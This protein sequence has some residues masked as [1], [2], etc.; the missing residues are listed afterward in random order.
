MPEA[1]ALGEVLLGLGRAL[2]VEYDVGAVLDSLADNVS[3]LLSLRGAAVSVSANRAVRHVASNCAALSG[4][5]A[6]EE[7]AQRGPTFDAVE[8]GLPVVVTSLDNGA[9]PWPEYIAQ[10]AAAGLGAVAAVP[11]SGHT[12]PVALTLAHEHEHDWSADELQV[13][14]MFARIAGH[15]V[16]GG[17]QLVKHRV[18]AEQLQ[19]A[20]DSRVIIEQ[21]KGFIAD[22]RGV[23][24]DDAFVIMRKYANDHHA[25]LRSVADAVVNLGLR[26]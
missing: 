21:A 20:L 3:T 12:P 13:A 7:E 23:T 19:I 18:T 6:A 22:N 16:L 2:N 5:C 11:T 25:T 1:A 8:S 24:V 9:S 17:S 15:L 4:L 26:P 10:A 14:A